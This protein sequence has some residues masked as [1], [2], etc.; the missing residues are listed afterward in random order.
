[1]ISAMKVEH[2]LTDR[3]YDTDQVLR[4]A[5]DQKMDAAI[6]PKKRKY[7]APTTRRS[8][9]YAIKRLLQN[10]LFPLFNISIGAL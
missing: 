7:A 8:A 5:Q 9:N 10:R 3:G 6:P 1:M 2:L 4:Q